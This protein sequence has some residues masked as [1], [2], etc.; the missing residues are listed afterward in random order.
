[1]AFSVAFA[2]DV[3]ERVAVVVVVAD[4]DCVAVCVLLRVNTDVLDP[5]G[6]IVD[7]FESDGEPVVVGLICGVYDNLGDIVPVLETVEVCEAAAERDI[8]VEPV[9]VFEGNA[10]IVR[11]ELRRDDT[12]Y[13]FVR[14]P[15]E[16]ADPDA[17][18]VGVTESTGLNVLNDVKDCIGELLTVFV[19]DAER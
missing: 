15:L 7:V 12:V 5:V 6:D 18:I 14:V 1:V 16:L 3:Y 8:V 4:T 17:D 2:V 13:R 10:D 11:V 19:A 9:D